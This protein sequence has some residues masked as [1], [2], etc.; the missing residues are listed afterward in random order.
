MF[1]ENIFENSFKG[2]YH[3]YLGQKGHGTFMYSTPTNICGSLGE[4]L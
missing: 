4:V 1:L 3:L 2:N